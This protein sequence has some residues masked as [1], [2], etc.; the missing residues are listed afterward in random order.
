MA[1]DTNN[2]KLLHITTVPQSLAFLHGQIGYMKAR[3]MDV[4]ALASPGEL[5]ASFAQ[6]EQIKVHPIEMPRR[7]T[8]LQDI[9]AII[10][11]L[12]VLWRVGPH[13]VHA[14]TPKGGLLGMIAAWLARVPIRIY[15]I[16]GLPLM[17][18]TGHKRILLR[19]SERVAC[20]CAHQVLCV[21]HSIR[22]VVV[23]EGF[24]PAEKIKVLHNGTINGID[25]K[26]RFDPGTI[27]PEVRQAT[28]T[29]Y[30]ISTHALVVG[31]VGRI[32]RDKGL[33]ELV[34]AW[35]VLC[36]EFPTLHLLI[37][38]PFEPQ[39]PIPRQTEHILRHTPRIHL[40]GQVDDIAP[41][42][43]SMDVLAFPTYREGFGLAALEA[44]AMNVPV[45]ATRI[46]G[47]VEAVQE[48]VTGKLVP[49]RDTDAL[50]DALRAYLMSP[51][52]RHR[53]GTAG[54]ERV[55]RCFQQEAIWAAMYQEY[56]RLLSNHG[57][58]TP[59]DTTP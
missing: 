12:L 7:I 46:P 32:V 18:A 48:G 1:E 13:I 3:D 11:L 37:A 42:Y 50:I 8:P 5:L 29:K 25:A 47:C 41:L 16:H 52:M 45:V 20:F 49:P 36:E 21:S 19:W 30:G 43:A 31:F 38:G 51:R 58:V 9:I 6:R 59:A 24:C 26:G 15:Q 53:H 56:A 54:R 39:D 40:A 27:S 17:T 4:Q 35:K 55:L 14:H 23:A 57:F 33:I 22:A 10:R 44:S 2:I 28:R 34:D